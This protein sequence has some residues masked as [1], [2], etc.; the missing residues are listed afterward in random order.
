MIQVNHLTKTFGQE[1][2]VDDISFD[3][4][5]G[6]VLG[7]LGP[8]GAG[9]STTMRVLTC[10]L[11][12]TA[13]SV[14]VDGRDVVEDSL[15]VRSMIGY[16]PESTPLYSE[17][18][19]IDYLKFIARLRGMPV[20][21]EKS[22]IAF[23]SDVCGLESVMRKQIDTLSKGFRQR[24]GLAQAMLHDPEIL[25]LDEPTSG[26]DPNQIVE[27]RELI[28]SL[29][30]EKTVIL[31]T[32]ILPEVQASCDRVL[33]INKGKIVAD[34]SPDRLQEQFS[35]GQRIQFG[36]LGDGSGV[37]EALTGLGS[38][39]IVDAS[40]DDGSTLFTLSADVTADLRPQL[41]D[42]AVDRGWRLTEL[43][44]EEASLEDVF[45]QLTSSESQLAK[46]VTS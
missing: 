35:G 25:V 21:A 12:P 29:G 36:V 24:V 22:R 30:Q 3:V 41:F 33:I 46:E 32:H 18:S 28:L 17:M 16:L 7:F 2:A 31:S 1:R 13:G 42:L 4:A 8:N 34:G 9:K 39:Q 15:A 5:T 14:S 38:L 10:Y 11:P 40:Q 43:H 23:V 27:I 44:R 37:E 45:R 26:L 19:V 6:E 20:E